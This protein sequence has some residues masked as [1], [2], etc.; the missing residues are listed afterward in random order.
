MSPQAS[1]TELSDEHQLA[2]ILAQKLAQTP[3]NDKKRPGEGQ[4]STEREKPKQPKNSPST[5]T[6]PTFPTNIMS[7]NNTNDQDNPKPKIIREKPTS[8]T[9]SECAN[10]YY[11]K[12]EIT[13]KEKH[14]SK[15]T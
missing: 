11:A 3:P 13:E 10:F 15:P 6:T 4:L 7:S 14:P 8:I 9:Q 2:T 1:Q 5:P 12:K